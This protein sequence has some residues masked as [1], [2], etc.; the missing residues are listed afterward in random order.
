MTKALLEGPLQRSGAITIQERSLA[1]GIG[2]ASIDVTIALTLEK[3]VVNQ[4]VPGGSTPPR[5]SFT[6]NMAKPLGSI[7][8]P[9]V[10]GKEPQRVNWMVNFLVVDLLSGYNAIMGRP[11]L[12]AIRAVA[13]T[14]HLKLKFPPATVLEK[15]ARANQRC[16]AVT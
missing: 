13:S 7:S 11:R 8:L 16:E 10:L 1:K 5:V 3:I 14:F 15:S 6:G 2:P 12:N 4:E 9:I